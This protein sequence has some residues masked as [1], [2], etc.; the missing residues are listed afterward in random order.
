M[1]RAA[2]LPT[3]AAVEPQPQQPGSGAAV[4]GGDPTSGEMMVA[5]VEYTVDRQSLTAGMTTA[6][7]R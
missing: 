6:G 7:A 3:I 5:I 1:R 2:R 4:R